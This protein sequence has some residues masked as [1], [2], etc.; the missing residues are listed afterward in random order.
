MTETSA[1]LPRG[2]GAASSASSGI[3]RRLSVWGLSASAGGAGPGT[4][5][6]APPTCESPRYASTELPNGEHDSGSGDGS[7]VA[8]APAPIAHAPSGGGLLSSFWSPMSR[9]EEL[10]KYFELPG[11]EVRGGERG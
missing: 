5:A 4:G 11:G 8:A 9:P 6:G 1:T 10:A 3:F 7:L 2:E